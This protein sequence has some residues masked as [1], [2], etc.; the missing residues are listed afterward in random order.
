MAGGGVSLYD[1]TTWVKAQHDRLLGKI[2]K[3]DLEELVLDDEDCQKYLTDDDI[4]AISQTCFKLK[5]LQIFGLE[6]LTRL[7]S[8]FFSNPLIFKSLEYLTIFNCPELKSIKIIAPLLKELKIDNEY[9]A[10]S[11]LRFSG[12]FS[13]SRS[14]EITAQASLKIFVKTKGRTFTIKRNSLRGDDL[15]LIKDAPIEELDLS[16]CDAL[17]DA[18][19]EPI[20]T[21]PLRKLDLS[22]CKQITYRGI[23][24]LIKCKFLHTLDLSSCVSFPVI[25]KTLTHLPLKNLSLNNPLPPPFLPEINKFG[26]LLEVLD[27]LKKLSLERFSLS[28]STELTDP[29]LFPL[30]ETNLKFLNLD[31]STKL[32]D[33]GLVH[34]KKI[35][36][37]KLSLAKC[38]KLTNAGLKHLEAIKTLQILNIKG[39]VRITE[40]GINSLKQAI[41]GIKIYHDQELN[42]RLDKGT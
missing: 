13:S 20:Q 24:Y 40:A 35:P 29:L 36:L 22:G 31:S 27:S 8:G 10:D 33:K 15:K 17:K 5:T 11:D 28:Q 32:S 34:L 25:F 6:K 9:S 39:C 23:A 37:Q 3:V 2:L 16:G 42:S 1:P 18:D 41:V 4:V 12:L 14:L 30:S 21:M 19:L 7:T 26:V 38:R